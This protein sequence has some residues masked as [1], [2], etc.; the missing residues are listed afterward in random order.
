[1]GWKT[2]GYQVI[3]GGRVEEF[4]EYA[5]ALKYALEQVGA[6]VAAGIGQAEAAKSVQMV[7]LQVLDFHAVA[8]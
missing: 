4:A 3:A 1:M 5:A 8:P 7:R 6:F 2:Y